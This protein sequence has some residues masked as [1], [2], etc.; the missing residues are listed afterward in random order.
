F[1]IVIVAIL[2]ALLTISAIA[3]DPPVLER[4][5]R[6]KYVIVAMQGE[7]GQLDFGDSLTTPQEDRHARDAAEEALRKWKRYT[8]TM[9]PNQ[10]ELLFVV[11]T[12]R[13]GSV[14]VRTG[15]PLN[16]KGRVTIGKV[17]NEPNTDTA[18]DSNRGVT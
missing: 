2:A 6:A 15:P 14:Y 12:A 8:V 4:L 11:R 5:V 13:R 1:P 16:S 10:A 7:K 3:Q 9:L 18:A 17:P